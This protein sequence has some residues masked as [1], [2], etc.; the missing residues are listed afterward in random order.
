MNIAPLSDTKSTASTASN[1]TTGSKQTTSAQESATAGPVSHAMDKAVARIQNQLDVTSAQ[2][3]SFGKLKSSVSEAQLSA[4][5]LSG[6]SGASTSASVRTALSRFLVGMN[7]AVTTAKTTAALP[8]SAISESGSAERV[9][10]DLMRSVTSNPSTV[11]A[12]KKLGFK[13]ESDGSFTWDGSKFDAAYAADPA[14]VRTT[15]AKLGQAVDPVATK[16][17]ATNANVGDSMTNLSL[18]ATTL[19]AQ[20]ASMLAVVQKLDAASNNGGNT[21]YINYGLSAYLS[22]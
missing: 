4:K 7:T 18:R 14:G 9:G 8:G 15:L 17:L 12:L 13:A 10:R 11:D 21:G 1:L 2:L 22:T 6:L 19:K 3:T 20:Q 16:A 5:A